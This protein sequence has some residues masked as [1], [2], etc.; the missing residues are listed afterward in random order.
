MPP[1]VLLMKRRILLYLAR[2]PACWLGLCS[3]AW[4][5]S[6]G[7]GGSGALTFASG[8]RCHSGRKNCK[9]QINWLSSAELRWSLIPRLTPVGAQKLNLGGYSAW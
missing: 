2:S 9:V 3:I 8:L 6:F 7:L 5:N 1:E 4:T